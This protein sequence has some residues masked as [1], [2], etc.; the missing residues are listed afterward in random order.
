[1]DGYATNQDLA[2]N[3]VIKTRVANAEHIFN[4]NKEEWKLE[5]E[6]V[7]TVTDYWDGP[8]KGIA[9]YQGEPHF[10]ECIFDVAADD[11][12]ESFLLTPLD[13]EFFQLAMEDWEIW[14]RW[15]SAFHQGKADKDTHPALAP[16][17]S[18][19]LELKQILDKAL[20]TDPQ[21]AFTRIG[22]LIVVGEPNLPPGVSR[23]LQ[24]KWTE[25]QKVPD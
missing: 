9:N 17:S 24:V 14:Q 6:P 16:E 23:P 7:F 12:S 22:K 10:Y 18:R 13:P 25:S 2:R 15:E 20:V 4:M 1:M 8:R 5:Y 21:R 3:C 11:Y 19:H